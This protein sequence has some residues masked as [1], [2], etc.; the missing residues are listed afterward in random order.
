MGPSGS[1]V[2]G[3]NLDTIFQACKE[4]DVPL[5]MEKLEG[6]TMCLIFLGIE[7]N[8]SS[9]SMRLPEEKLARLHQ[10]LQSRARRKACTSRERKSLVGLLHHACRV[11][12]PRRLFLRQM[13]DLHRIPRRQ[14][15]QLRLNRQ[16]RAD[17]RW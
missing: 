3:C 8:T 10:A 16:F 6:R 13:I 4:L 5:A 14:H 9:G 2:C 15:H 17:L 7:I 12:C 11:I 1:Q